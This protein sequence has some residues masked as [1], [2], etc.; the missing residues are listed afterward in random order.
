MKNNNNIMNRIVARKPLAALLMVATSLLFC[1]SAWAYDGGIQYE[2][3]SGLSFVVNGHQIYR[4]N[5]EPVGNKHDFGT[6]V[7]LE[8]TSLSLKSWET[9]TSTSENFKLC[10][11][12]FL[13]KIKYP[14]NVDGTVVSEGSKGLETVNWGSC[15][16]GYQYPQWSD[17]SKINLIEGL[18]TPG[19]YRAEFWFKLQGKGN[20]SSAECDDW[21]QYGRAKGTCKKP[22]EGSDSDNFYVT[23]TLPGF[24]ETSAS[25]DFGSVALNSSSSQ[26]V[27]FTQHYGTALTTSDCVISGFY[28]SQF[29]VVSISETGVKVRFAPTGA[30]GTRQATLTITDANDK[31]CQIALSGN[32][33]AAPVSNAPTVY[34]YSTEQQPSLYTWKY[35]D[36]SKKYNG[37]WPGA[38]M[39]ATG[40]ED[41]YSL[42]LGGDATSD[43]KYKLIFNNGNTGSMKQTDNLGGDGVTGDVAGYFDINGASQAARGA[44]YNIT[45]HGSWGWSETALATTFNGSK[46]A[47]M[48]TTSKMLAPGDYEF[49]SYSNGT[50]DNNIVADGFCRGN[51]KLKKSGN[52]AA[53]HLDK[54]SKV[55][56]YC[57]PGPVNH[58]VFA[59]VEEMTPVFIANKE[60]IVNDNT[61]NLTGY[62]KYTLCDGNITQYGFSYSTNA[63][64]SDWKNAEIIQATGWGTT[65]LTAKSKFSGSETIGEVGTY[66]YKS[67]AVIDGVYQFSTETRSFTI[68][69]IHPRVSITCP[70]SDVVYP[71]EA[72]SL[73]ATGSNYTGTMQWSFTSTGA[74]PEIVSTEADNVSTAVVKI[75]RPEGTVGHVFTPAIPYTITVSATLEDE[76]VSESCIVNLT[77]VDEECT[78]ST[79]QE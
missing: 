53:F 76:T 64:E 70:A 17:A 31:T 58:I 16:N 38:A 7:K 10:N 63:E 56:F 47:M 13:Y 72:F 46:M 75:P 19:K 20:D 69:A 40:F 36:D 50:A 49:L 18:S 57:D 51:L 55:T 77:D 9:C 41:W 71:Y 73:S 24:E 12:L 59:D 52:N 32:A 37:S 66:Y 65:A 1:S 33:T 42:A 61:V 67:F 39:V 21:W 26:D 60:R 25:K 79:P 8:A 4:S 11:S 29:S 30:T 54:Y 74:A 22:T 5:S 14:D 15:S 3:G 45:F 35:N 43:T 34:V 68:N 2:S 48:S 78:N 23:F 28:A 44:L 6:V 62:L 27:S